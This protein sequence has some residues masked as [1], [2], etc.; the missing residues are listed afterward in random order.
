VGRPAINPRSLTAVWT[1]ALLRGVTSSVRL[2]TLCGQD[3]EFRW[4]LG[5]VT[6]EKTALCDFRKFYQSE[7]ASL[8]AQVLGALGQH[9]L[10]PGKD[11]GMDGT[12]V[13]AASSRHS[14]KSRRRL[15]KRQQHL[16]AVIEEKLSQMDGDWESEEVKALERRRQRVADALAEMDARGITEQ[17]GRLTVTEPD[18]SVK[19]QKDHSFAPGYNVQVVT[20]L[21]SG[22]IV[23]AEVVDAGNDCGQLQPQLEHAQAAL[24]EL[25]GNEERKIESITADSAYHDTRQLDHLE[26]QRVTCYVPEDRNTHRQAP[27]VSPAYQA[28]RFTYNEKTDTMKCPL[29]QDLNWR[30]LNKN[31]T[32]AVYQARARV[33]QAC[34]A[35]SQCCPTSNSGRCASRPLPIYKETL[36]KVAG[37]LETE[38]GQH[39]KHA[40]WVTCEGIY[41][42]FSDLLHWSR[43]RMWNRAGAEMELLWR[44]FTHNLMLW[45]G[46][47]KPLVAK[48][49]A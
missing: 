29:G 7:L 45:L 22:V 32:A 25:A 24:E 27:G 9:D 30:K 1:L 4:L 31:K 40:R 10:L 16:R 21:D 17:T 28:D 3:I 20:D 6:V 12:I 2:A 26:G 19:Q 35:Q 23:H 13:R 18:A 11:M 44:Q 43:C 41:A 42:R 33:C 46:V 14:S 49:K 34:P 47:W 36:D 15:E 37:R 38:E 8:S 5:D 48:A 39:K